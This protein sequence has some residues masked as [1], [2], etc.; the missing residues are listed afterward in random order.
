[1]G[2]EVFVFERSRQAEQNHVV[3]SLSQIR[4]F[5]KF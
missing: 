4:L 3:C 1:M 5:L 2:R